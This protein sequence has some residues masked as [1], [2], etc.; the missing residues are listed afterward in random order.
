MAVWSIL[1][2]ILLSLAI[3]AYWRADERERRQHATELRK[4]KG[5]D[6]GQ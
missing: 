4:R 2:S 1:A 6:H 3:A 5:L